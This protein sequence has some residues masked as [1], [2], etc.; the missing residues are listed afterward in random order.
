M[1]GGFCGYIACR[2]VPVA[3]SRP[4]GLC[5]NVFTDLWTK[6]PIRIF[7][8]RSPQG[9][10]HVCTASAQGDRDW[11]Q[12]RARRPLSTIDYI[13]DAAPCSS[14]HAQLPITACVPC[15]ACRRMQ[16]AAHERKPRLCT[17]R[18]SGHAVDRGSHAVCAL[19]C[20]EAACIRYERSCPLP[21]GSSGLNSY[22]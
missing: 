21:T 5:G 12:D 20:Y 10:L 19:R 7:L 3:D 17:R 6:W 16:H 13:Q 18:R 4:R 11:T 1:T 2:P 8:D 9:D 14:I 22:L 15:T